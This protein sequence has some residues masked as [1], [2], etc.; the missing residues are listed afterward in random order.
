MSWEE[1]VSNTAGTGP[2]SK[3]ALH[4]LECGLK[5]SKKSAITNFIN[6][7]LECINAICFVYLGHYTLGKAEKQEVIY[8]YIIM[9]FCLLY[10]LHGMWNKW[11]TEKKDA[12]CMSKLATI[13]DNREF[14]SHKYGAEAVVAAC[15]DADYSSSSLHTAVQG[16]DPS[17]TPVYNVVGADGDEDLLSV[18]LVEMEIDQLEVMLQGMCVAYPEEEDE[19]VVTVSQGRVAR[20]AAAFELR[21]SAVSLCTIAPYS[22]TIFILNILALWGYTV[23]ILNFYQIPSKLQLGLSTEVSD[24]WGEFTGNAAWTLEPM[25]VLYVLWRA[26]GKEN[27]KDSS[28]KEKFD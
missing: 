18:D 15:L 12:V 24:W 2:A 5:S 26:V 1:N 28:I 8:S 6:G 27:Q 13:L 23:V 16:I 14:P 25:I 20:S 7:V 17:Y 22:L 10:F 11:R 9:N 4:I 21:R 3:A 19:D